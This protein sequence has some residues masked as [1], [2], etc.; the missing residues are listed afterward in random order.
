MA[1]ADQRGG[2]RD[3]LLFW[4]AAGVND[5][6]IDG[7]GNAASISA[8]GYN[9]VAG[10]DWN[11]GGS[12]IGGMVGHTTGETEVR[13][14]K[15]DIAAT[16]VGVYGGT[17]TM[18]AGFSAR[19]SYA[20]A[21]GDADTVRSIAFGGLARTAR[22]EYGFDTTS[23]SA[24]ARLGF[25]LGEG[26]LAWGPAGLLDHAKVERKR[27]SETG[28]NSLN[29]SGESDEDTRW[30][31][32]LGGFVNWKAS[33]VT[34]DASVMYARRD[35]D[36]TETTLRMA[37]LPSQ[38]FDVRS[39]ETESGGMRLAARGEYAIGGGWSVGASY[40]G[41]LGGGEDNHAALVTVALR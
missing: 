11:T 26:G 9:A 6:G 31:F 21:M 39:P 37:G 8:T 29:L 34:V 7:D 22:A 4:G 18:G 16:L 3:G 10:L 20:M 40:Q 5:T 15:A 25:P 36:F 13:A 17:G 19:A 28:A 1:A 27:F 32:G 38:S 35:G 41:W 24:E 23:F 12:W 14:D 2:A 30:A 33:D